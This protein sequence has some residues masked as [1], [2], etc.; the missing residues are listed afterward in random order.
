MPPE[1]QQQAIELNR[2]FY[3][4]YFLGFLYGL[5]IYLFILRRRLAMRL[6]NLAERATSRRLLQAAI[7]VPLLL[8]TIALL[9]LP[10]SI[11]GHWLLRKYGLSVESWGMW[12]L[13]WL[14]GQAINIVVVTFVVWIFYG[15]M[16]RSPRRWWFYAW[17]VSIPLAVFAVVLAPVVIDPLFYKFE[18][19][20]QT[21]PQLVRE[22][23]RVVAHAGLKI[24]PER[25]FEMKASAKTREFNAYV[26]GLGPTKRVVVWDTAMHDSRT[27]EILATFGHEMGHYVLGHIW[28]KGLTLS[29]IGLFVAL[30]L[31]HRLAVV[32]EKQ[33][34]HAWG[35][36]TMDDWASLPLFLLLFSLFSFFGAPVENALS[37]YFEHQADVYGLEVIHG[38]VPNSGEAAAVCLQRMGET[39]LEDPEPPAFIRFWL[40]SHPPVNDRIILART[41]D[42]W[43]KGEKPYFVP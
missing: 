21:R 14:K 4:R 26:T 38:I 33:W 41:Y 28:W 30:Y 12:V 40:S 37:R 22:M 16:R 24:P 35:I 32:A 23:E 17:L 1:K 43:A 29:F 11:S 9:N 18:P 3:W 8:L 6:R 42:P 7:V 2:A 34:G 25:I 13:D 15:L 20:A 19:L 36:L 27:P 39:D 5:L 31:A 10:R